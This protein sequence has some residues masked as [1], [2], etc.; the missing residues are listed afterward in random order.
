MADLRGQGRAL[1]VP[2]APYNHPR[3]SPD[4]RWLA[5]DTDSSADASI[6]LYD[7]SGAAQIRRLTLT[8]H[9]TRI[10]QPAAAVCSISNDRVSSARTSVFWNSDIRILRDLPNLD[11]C[12][13]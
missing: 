10:S 13:A 11:Y 8:G 3:V 7:L 2:P 6:Y 12:G 1:T 5:V 9:I 4:G